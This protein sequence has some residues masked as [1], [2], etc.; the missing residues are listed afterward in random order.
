[1]RFIRVTLMVIGALAVLA[2]IA[3][4][5]FI[6]WARSVFGTGDHSFSRERWIAEGRGP[7]TENDRNQMLDEVRPRL[8]PG[9]ART[10]VIAALGPPDSGSA[11]RIT[12]DLGT[13]PFGV[14]Y[15]YLHIAF[16]GEGR[17]IR[18]WIEQG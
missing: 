6:L 1:M 3:L 5:V 14:D 13:T 10:E 2:A 18:H 7:G 4:A 12:Y 8:L 17:L 16:D 11:E 15:H 9:M